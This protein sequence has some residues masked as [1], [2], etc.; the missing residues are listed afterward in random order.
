M[1]RTLMA[2][3]ILAAFVAIPASAAPYVGAGIGASRTDSHNT[4][5]K[6]FAGFQ[7]NENFGVQ[8]AYNNFGGYRGATATAWSVAAV[9]TIP[10]DSNWDISGKLGATENRTT[11][12]GAGRHSDILWG[13]GVGY[14]F[15]KNIAV[16][17]E[18]EDFGKLPTD[19]AGNR[20][21]ATNWGLN[22]K[23]SF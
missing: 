15:N 19:N 8:V 16:R 9:G 22:A 1:K 7:S 12:P 11:L 21:K 13:L 23:Y 17:F 6:I 2:A 5:S 3:A 18:Y 20:W 14:N 4:A 10:L